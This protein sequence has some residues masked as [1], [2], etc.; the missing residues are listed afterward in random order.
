[1]RREWKT[2]EEEKRESKE[3]KQ[4]KRED[5]AAG[6]VILGMRNWEKGSP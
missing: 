6:R 4:I 5:Q 2:R 1:M 3:E